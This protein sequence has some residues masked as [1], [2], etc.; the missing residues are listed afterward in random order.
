MAEFSFNATT[1]LEGGKDCRYE[2]RRELVLD[3][4]VLNIL[5]FANQI[6]LWFLETLG[7]LETSTVRMPSEAPGCRLDKCVGQDVEQH[8]NFGNGKEDQLVDHDQN[9]VE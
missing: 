1:N 5:F 7:L 3:C 6:L 2:V 9:E 8:G 4:H